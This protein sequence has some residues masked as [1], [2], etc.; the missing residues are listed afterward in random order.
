MELPADVRAAMPY[1]LASDI[2]HDHGISIVTKKVIDTVVGKPIQPP[3][4]TNEDRVVVFFDQL[5]SNYDE[6]KRVLEGRQVFELPSS[7]ETLPATLDWTLPD[8]FAFVHDAGPKLFKL[9]GKD[10][11]VTYGTILDSAT[12]PTESMKFAP[13]PPAVGLDI[14]QALGFSSVVGP[15]ELT[16]VTDTSIKAVL[17]YGGKRYDMAGA[18]PLTI[19]SAPT[20][21]KLISKPAGF[22]ASVN[23]VKKKIELK[24][25]RVPLYII[26]KALGDALQ[27]LSVLQAQPDV[28]I[29]LIHNTEDRLN[30]VRCRVFDVPAIHVG[31]VTKQSPV[32]I[33]EFI[34]SRAM[35]VDTPETR[36]ARYLG[37]LKGFL[38][39]TA[40]NYD[41]VIQQFRDPQTTLAPQLSESYRAEAV[42]QIQLLKIGTLFHFMTWFLYYDAKKAA[43]TDEDV[44]SI[45]TSH[46]NLSASAKRLSPYGSIT[47]LNGLDYVQK[48]IVCHAPPDD[49]DLGGFPIVSEGGTDLRTRA[50]TIVKVLF[51]L[52]PLGEIKEGDKQLKIDVSKLETLL[53]EVG[54]QTQPLIR[55][56][57]EVSIPSGGGAGYGIRGTYYF[58]LIQDAKSGKPVPS[59][60]L[61]GG[62]A[63]KRKREDLESPGAP[64]VKRARQEDTVIGTDDASL[65]RWYV[66]SKASD[67]TPGD[68]LGYVKRL[69]DAGTGNDEVYDFGLIDT[70]ENEGVVPDISTPNRDRCLRVWNAFI[71]FV[72]HGLLNRGKGN[73]WISLHERDI[74]ADSDPILSE[75][76]REETRLLTVEDRLVRPEIE[77]EPPPTRREVALPVGAS[78]IPPPHG[79]SQRDWDEALDELE[80]RYN[81]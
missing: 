8:D 27:V 50:D 59:R 28:P 30:F 49:C 48:F 16:R 52:L 9:T 40:S 18:N 61:V 44:K 58:E 45:S 13:I 19:P 6:Y 60:T 43:P 29:R 53:T 22:L 65:F 7:T 66:S 47:R 54:I 55:P 63:P 72:N 31:R 11:Y 69:K 4:D 14:F 23:D 39:I 70:I 76:L 35:M 2:A 20:Q 56:P 57:S 12:K 51:G 10:N 17:T 26:G 77:T 71:I 15:L 36:F 75:L 81:K 74:E 3:V 25:S 41:R 64:P 32:R 73:S 80:A 1:H 21:P 79:I 38:Q 34:P 68:V 42:R 5:L 46:D 33:C 62:A 78:R 37:K 24:D 67:V